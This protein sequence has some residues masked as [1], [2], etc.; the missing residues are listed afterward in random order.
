MQTPL[1]AAAR[2]RREVP[3]ELLAEHVHAAHDRGDLE[4]HRALVGPD[5]AQDRLAELV[6]QDL[7]AGAEHRLESVSAE[8]E[9]ERHRRTRD[10][11]QRDQ[12]RRPAVATAL[13]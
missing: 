5:L 10:R 9:A 12:D 13:G 1:N 11:D 3:P 2:A 7:A 6:E 4:S 8:L